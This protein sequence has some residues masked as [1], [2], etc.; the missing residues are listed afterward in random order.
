[1]QVALFNRTLLQVLLV[2][3]EKLK[4]LMLAT[5]TSC[6]DRKNPTKTLCHCQDRKNPTKTLCHCQDRKKSHKDT[7]SLS[8]QKNPTT[9]PC[10]FQDR[11]KSHKDTVSLSGQKKSHN[12]TVSLSGQK[13]NP[14]RHRVGICSLMQPSCQPMCKGLTASNTRP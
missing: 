11:K 6:Q 12:D 9:I 2:T 14:Q 10:H 8:G 1:M 13:K 4:D 3:M 7:V 5:N